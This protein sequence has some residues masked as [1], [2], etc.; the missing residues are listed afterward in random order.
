MKTVRVVYD[1]EWYIDCVNGDDANDG[2]LAH[3]KRTIRAATTNAVAGDVIHVAPG[4]YGALEGSQKWPD[5]TSAIGTRVVIPAGV[6]V[7]ST[8]GATNTFIVGEASPDPA[9]T[10]GW[11]AGIGPG[12]VRCVVAEK[13]ATLR[14]FTLKE[15]YTHAGTSA[16][17]K[18]R[19][20]SAFYSASA[21]GAAIE[22]CVVSNNVAH[23]YT[24]YQAVVRRCRVIGN[25]AANGTDNTTSGAAGNACAWYNSIIANNNGNATLLNPVV[26]ESCTI[27]NGNVYI[28]GTSA[29]ALYWND[30]KP[31][32]IFNTVWING[33]LQMSGSTQ[34]YCTNC[35]VNSS[36][37]GTNLS[38][39]NCSN[40]LFMTA[41]EMK[42]DS[43]YRPNL[44]SPA[45]DAGDA[46][47]S[48]SALG[49]TDILGT[50]RVLNGA[51]DIGA[52]EYDWRPTFN[53]E[54]GRRF[55]LA[56]VSPSV[57]TN[58]A[59]GVLVPDG[60][61]A[62]TVTSAGPYEIA[63]S[64]TG[65][66]LAVYVGGEL[67]D[68]SSGAGEQSIRFIVADAADEVR[69]VFTP[70]AENPGSA[71]LKKVSGA[72]GFSISFR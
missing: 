54:L 1:T 38:R 46:A 11:Q 28:P 40:T 32:A 51:L 30:G 69:F 71:V 15:G 59:G 44:D 62:G 31:K 17:E 4:T 61:V 22:D 58:A 5:D 9:V 35:L 16:L 55:K 21:L 65:G 24:M 63:F 47:Y 19:Y 53:A 33:R 52:V 37:L 12:A 29:Q 45:I 39:D 2:S 26:V 72:R 70:D 56:D 10:E 8:G 43:E 13:G 20:C 66:G 18:D 60:S 34:L 42:F 7:E 14:G 27:G 25:T 41:S 6:T 36:R 49:D 68:E 48:S 67:A 50:P 3:P 64:V 23:T 57:T